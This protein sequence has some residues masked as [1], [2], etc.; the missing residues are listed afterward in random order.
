ML[1]YPANL[2]ISQK[3]E[4]ILQTIRDH[5]VIVIAGA[6]GSGKT[7]QLPKMCLELLASLKRFRVGCTQPRRIATLSISS[8]I[9]KEMENTPF[10]VAH[11]IRFSDTTT[12]DTH[13]KFMTDGVLLAEIRD[14][15]LLKQYNTLIIDE[16]HERS[17]NIDFLLGHLKQ[18]LPKRTDLKV[19]ITSAT[20]DTRAFSKHFNNAPVIAIEGKTYPV[21]TRYE[22]LAEDEQGEPESYV[23][24]CIS[25]TKRI[26]ASEPPGDILIF[27]P[28]ERDILNCAKNLKK[29]TDDTLVLPLFGRLHSG[30]QQKIF[31]PSKHTKIVIATNVAE[32]SITVPGIR[33][34]IDTGLARMAY[35]N[36]RAGTNSLPVKKISQSSCD[37][38]KGR[39]GRV[40]PGVCIRLFSEDD[41]QQRDQY[42]LPEIKRS[43]LADVLL[44]MV[45]FGLGDPETFPF[46]DPP[47]KS[48]IREGYKHLRELDALS[49]K[50]ELTNIGRIM[51]TMP[52]DPSIA[53]I[54]I[55][56]H[57]NNC[58][59]EIMVIAA[60]L[61][62]QDPQIRPLEYEKE[63][64]SAH[65]EFAHPQSDFFFYYNIWQALH[66]DGE[67]VSW[68]KLKKFCKSNYLSFQRMR[69]WLDLHDQMKKIISSHTA[70]SAATSNKQY[71]RRTQKTEQLSYEAVHKSLI[72]GFIRNI[73][74]RKEGKIY[75]G[76]ANKELLI[77]PGSHQAS[78]KFQWILAA[79]FL[80]TSSLFA[81]TVAAIE[82]EWIEA[83][84]GRHCR[85]SWSHPAFSRKMGKVMARERVSLFGLVIT[86]DRQV[87][88]AKTTAKNAEE[89]RTI[90]IEEGLVNHRIYGTYRFLEKN[91]ELLKKWQDIESRLRQRSLLYP[92]EV[93]AEF[94][95][96]KLP[97]WVVDRS[98]LNRFLKRGKN[99]NAL[100]LQEN[101]ILQKRPQE[102][103]LADF[104]PSL[105]V[106][107][108]TF[109]LEY[110]FDPS[111]DSDGVTITLPLDLASVLSPHT[112]EWLVP[113]LL[114][115]KIT[116]LLKSLP[117][118][119]RKHL[120]PVTET[121]DRILDDSDQYTG[122]LYKAMERSIFK[123][124]KISISASE[125]TTELPGH[126]RM[127][128]K[129]I[130]VEGKE[131]ASGRDLASLVAT[132]KR[133]EKIPTLVHVSAKDKALMKEYQK[134][135]Y[136]SW[137]FQQ[138]PE[139]IPIITQSGD[140]SGYYYPSVQIDEKAAVPQLTITFL[141]DR[142]RS[143]SGNLACLH[144]YLQKKYTKQ[145]K[146]LKKYCVTK[147]SGPSALWFI[148]LFSSK[149]Q[150]VETVLHHVSK[151]IFL[152]KDQ[153]DLDDILT[154]Q[155][156]NITRSDIYPTG[157]KII[158][159]ILALLRLRTEVYSELHRYK[160][161]SSQ[162]NASPQELFEE[163]E[164]SVEALLPATF[165]TDS[166]S[167]SIADI[168]RYLRGI[169]V[170]VARAY[171]DFSKD[172]KK[173]K[174]IR[175]YADFCTTMRS[176]KHLSFSQKTKCHHFN[177]MVEEYRLLLFAPEIKPKFS[178]SAKKLDSLKAEIQ[179]ELP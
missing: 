63:A 138:V 94:Y 173:Q 79:S 81:L 96:K 33:Y 26:L 1:D 98:S 74:L 5:Q 54:I 37:Q 125:W 174:L 134:K 50:N 164:N 136:T 100:L 152:S 169:S 121:A 90:F 16:A 31:A 69:E 102:N 131:V 176:L 139:A 114:H 8:R 85:Y 82:P 7:T 6:T 48:A 110:T 166:S 72:V 35:Y 40:G 135:T 22:P 25:C 133:P 122:S 52:I 105:T 67:R 120:V 14:D 77:F 160:T 30:D 113:G 60:V 15:P 70:F 32:T 89:A 123:Q 117:K 95:Q 65:Q 106:G 78:K 41:F 156:Q 142:S 28:T 4:E 21:E 157:V 101:D 61:A 153:Y 167:F 92:D 62:I 49:E 11:K 38:R 149:N 107:S 83:V 147:L 39:C 127:R 109:K 91:R 178:V 73:A 168:S 155:E 75:Q 104:P 57:R 56:A 119:I 34:I 9:V 59:S 43:N 76:A 151:E 170:R 80:E 177:E 71:S 51:S 144:I 132:V 103:E 2:P 68:S 20:I 55:E 29:Q 99:H 27:L 171:A 88:Y 66:S 161:L 140:I 145:F 42:T 129:L 128:F 146:P 111:Q 163:L 87:D 45:S 47:H 130:D 13:I 116:Y 137:D 46:L 86:A 143:I 17:L 179:H 58:L 108:H 19:V 53:R 148:K 112:F 24:G 159:S 3:K 118:R 165:L 175:P 172:I 141:T 158:D 115:E 162:I 44:R 10:K 12:E 150:A 97:H 18:I 126:L 64:D 23:D 93:I 154:F 36:F 124:K 84:A